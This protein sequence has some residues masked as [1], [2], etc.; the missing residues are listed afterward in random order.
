[1]AV[2]SDGRSAR[3]DVTTLERLPTCSLVRAVP[4]TGRT[5]QIRVH[6]AALGHPIAGDA[7]YGR[8][9]PLLL[10]QSGHQPPRR[11]VIPR[12][13]LHAAQLGFTLPSTGAWREFVS[14]LPTDLAEVLSAL[15]AAL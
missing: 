2:V 6:L 5:H 13:F 14:P 1:M 8:G 7:V 10:P 4:L 9:G 3:T 12:Q 11:L 15:R